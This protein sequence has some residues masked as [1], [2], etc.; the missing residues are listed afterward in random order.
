MTSWTKAEALFLLPVVS[1][2]V[3]P[4]KVMRRVQKSFNITLGGQR[5]IFRNLGTLSAI[6]RVAFY[7]S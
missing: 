1:F 3:P 6:S 5:C 4:K 2:L 7:F